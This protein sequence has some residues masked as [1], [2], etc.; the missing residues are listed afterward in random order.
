[1]ISILPCLEY[2]HGREL[3]AE[4][5]QREERVKRKLAR[6]RRMH[7]VS[8]DGEHHVEDEHRRWRQHSTA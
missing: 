4:G 5:D 3:L 2:V 1:M 6:V 7:F 8:E